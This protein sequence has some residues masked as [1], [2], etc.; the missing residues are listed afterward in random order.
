MLKPHEEHKHE[1]LRVI[2]LIGI[3]FYVS[4]SGYSFSLSSL[5]SA[6]CLFLFETYV[7]Y[8]IALTLGLH[9]SW[10]C[11]IVSLIKNIDWEVNMS[12]SR[13]EYDQ[14]SE[15]TEF[16]GDYEALKLVVERLEHS[17]FLLDELVEN[18][19]S[20]S[21][22]L[23][24]GGC[25]IS[26]FLESSCAFEALDFWSSLSDEV[27]WDIRWSVSDLHDDY[28]RYVTEIQTETELYG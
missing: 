17:S 19:Y 5:H 22:D 6:K 2:F 24:V 15:L 9:S 18:F 16:H 13:Y 11:V 23:P 14:F 1:A 8:T 28:V 7:F 20:E 4:V 27:A 3:F 25:V 26:W 12:S 21:T 10:D